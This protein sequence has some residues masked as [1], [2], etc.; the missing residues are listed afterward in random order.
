[1]KTLALIAALIAAAA[2]M[3]Q[4]LMQMSRDMDAP[5]LA[6]AQEQ[7]AQPFGAQPSAAQLA[8]IQSNY[9][10]TMAADRAALVISGVTLDDEHVKALRAVQR[11]LPPRARSQAAAIRAALMLVAELLAAKGAKK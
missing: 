8:A 10:T 4:A 3:Q 5:V 11:S 1:M 6:I 9:A 7:A 2:G